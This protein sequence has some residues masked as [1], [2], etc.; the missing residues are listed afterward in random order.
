MPKKSRF[1]RLPADLGLHLEQ[2]ADPDAADEKTWTLAI[3][4]ALT[5]QSGLTFCNEVKFAFREEMPTLHQLQRPHH[6]AWCISA[7]VDI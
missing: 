6:H 3:G 1:I 5:S 4:D 2:V 7:L